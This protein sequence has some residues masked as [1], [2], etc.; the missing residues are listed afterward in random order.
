VDE[1][2]GANAGLVI[3]EIELGAADE[4]FERPAWLGEEVTAEPRYYSFVLAQA[5]FSAWPAEQRRAAR[6][7]RHLE[8]REG[9]AA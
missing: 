1:F 6:A 9:D 5:P 8:D 2:L 4:A 7:G 3:A